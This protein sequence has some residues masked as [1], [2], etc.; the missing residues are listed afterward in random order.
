MISFIY[1]SVLHHKDVLKLDVSMKDVFVM[2]ILQSQTNLR[3][4]SE[5]LKNRL[6]KE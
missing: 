4:P 1:E 6:I 5:N 3:E 2:Q